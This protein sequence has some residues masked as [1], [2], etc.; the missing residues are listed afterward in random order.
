M[1]SGFAEGRLELDRPA[2]AGRE[3]QRTLHTPVFDAA[4][5]L[6]GVFGIVQSRPDPSL[7]L[8][9][10]IPAIDPLQPAREARMRQAEEELARLTE[11]LQ[12]LV[13]RQQQLQEEERRS[14][15][16]A[17][18]AC[19]ADLDGGAQPVEQKTRPADG[20]AAAAREVPA[21]LQRLAQRLWPHELEAQGLAEALRLHVHAVSANA[22]VRVRFSENL[23]GERFAPALEHGCFAVMQEALDNAL[24]HARARIVE[25]SLARR[26]GHLWLSVQDDGIGFDPDVVAHAPNLGLL[27]MRAR[28]RALGGD[29]DLDARPRGGTRIL[30][31]FPLPRSQGNGA[32]GL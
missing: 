10:P 32:S 28:V 30:A 9:D 6:V 20:A 7:R 11:Q 1:A 4:G 12:G 5:D 25:I 3:P 26:G 2:F 8:A 31:S 17:L 14:L 23:G 15:A 18:R 19:A 16:A 24:R 13:L 29:F 27:G 21:A 22:G